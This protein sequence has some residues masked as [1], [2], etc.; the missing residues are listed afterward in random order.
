MNARKMPTVI[1]V[2]VVVAVVAGALV[3][4]RQVFG[5]SPPRDQADMI[6]LYQADPLLMV[7]PNGGQL[8]EEYAHSYTCDSGMPYGG[9]PTSPSFAEVMRLYKTPTPHSQEQLRQRFDQPAAAAGWR[10]DPEHGSVAYCKQAGSR[11]S[12][13]RVS[14]TIYTANADDPP[15]LGVKV[16]L[17]AAADGMTCSGDND[18]RSFVDPVD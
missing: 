16:I 4:T 5:C 3:I 18:G 1:G 17:S 12:Y 11:A 2:A 8:V 14:P 13:A 6:Q 9:S 15:E 10:T 7:V